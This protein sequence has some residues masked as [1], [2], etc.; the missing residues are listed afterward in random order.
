MT[1]SWVFRSKVETYIQPFRCRFFL[2]H[3][4]KPTSLFDD[5]NLREKNK[6]IYEIQSEHFELDEKLRLYMWGVPNKRACSLIKFLKIFHP[7]CSYQSLLHYQ[8]FGNFLAYSTLFYYILLVYYIYIEFMPFTLSI[9]N[10][11]WPISA[12]VWQFLDFYDHYLIMK[13][14]WWVLLIWEQ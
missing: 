14:C 12:T 8:F 1:F 4:G 7:A 2:H 5:R 9:F 13:T 6:K 11:Q 3:I 10:K